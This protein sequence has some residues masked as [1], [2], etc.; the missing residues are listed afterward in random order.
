M[1][2]LRT[3][4]ADLPNLVSAGPYR[5][6]RVIAGREIILVRNPAYWGSA[7]NLARI[8]FRVEPDAAA[9]IAALRDD[10]VT[11]AQLS[12]G[13]AVHQLI[14]STTDLVGQSSFFTRSS[15]SSY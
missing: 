9:T 4:A 11:V 1:P 3:I 14:T 15:G 8:I 7:A 13:P 2:P 12:P 5:I 6:S 10:K